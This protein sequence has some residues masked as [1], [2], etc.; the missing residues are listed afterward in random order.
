MAGKRAFLDEVFSAVRISETF[1]R[2]GIKETFF[3]FVTDIRWNE[4]FAGV[5]DFEAFI[6]YARTWRNI[7]R[8]YLVELANNPKANVRLVLP[9][10][11]NPTVLAEIARR[12]NTEP[13]HLKKLM[14][15]SIADYDAIFSNGRCTS[16]RVLVPTTPVYTYY[17][18]DT[19]I[20]VALYR[21]GDQRGT[22]PAF[23]I[24]RGGLYDFFTND[25]NELFGEPEPL[26]EPN[27][28]LQA[29]ESAS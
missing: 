15:D 1:R 29:N 2:A 5:N 23:L 24:S 19:R 11:E 12:F 13:E 8:G 3:N 14:Q 18:F 28:A 17:R 4:L 10:P 9:D 25:M 20:L 6:S 22:V 7:V 21:N 16:K 27:Q 26:A